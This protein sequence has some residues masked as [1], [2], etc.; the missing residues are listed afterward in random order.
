M[1]RI[2]SMGQAPRWTSMMH[3]AIEQ[4]GDH[5][6]FSEMQPEAQPIEENGGIRHLSYNSQEVLKQ[7]NQTQMNAELTRN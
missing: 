6:V 5:D 2:S 4:E 7:V 3:R 1:L